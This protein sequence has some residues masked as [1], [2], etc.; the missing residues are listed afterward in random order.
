MMEG[1]VGGQ[2]ERIHV[3]ELL[4]SFQLF[5]IP[6][7]DLVLSPFAGLLLVYQQPW[8]LTWRMPFCPVLYFPFFLALFCGGDHSELQRKEETETNE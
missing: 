7:L 4:F 8:W 1:Y 5:F 6:L 3:S 2:G